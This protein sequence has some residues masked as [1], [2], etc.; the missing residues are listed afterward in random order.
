LSDI[1]IA[2]EYRREALFHHY[3]NLQIGPRL[4]QQTERGRGEYAIA[5]RPQT[6]DRY[7]CA[8]RQ[9]V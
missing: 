9:A 5:Q 8:G 7:P 2:G 1:R 3:R 4:F 6:D